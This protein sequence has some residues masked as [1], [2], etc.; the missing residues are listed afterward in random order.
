MADETPMQA[1]LQAP[2][3]WAD[4]QTLIRDEIE[5]K[6]PYI[7]EMYK[8]YYMYGN[9]RKAELQ[10][11]DE[12]RRTN[13]VSPI[14]NM[15]VSRL[16]NM[17]MEAD[18]RFVAMNKN[19]NIEDDLAKQLS[20]EM[21]DWAYYA[22]AKDESQAAFASTIFDAWL[23][24]RWVFKVGYKYVTYKRKYIDKQWW[25]SKELDIK[26]DYP[27]LYYISPY[28]I[29][30]DPAAKTINDA[31]FIAERKLLNDAEINRQYSIYGIS[32]TEADAKILDWL[33]SNWTTAKDFDSIKK[34]M[35]FYGSSQIRDI[36]EDSTYNIKRQTREVVEVHSKNSIT[37]YIN[38]KKYGTF[39]ALGPNESY[40]YKVI[41]FKENPWTLYSLGVWYVVKPLQD[42]YD[43]I[44]NLRLDNVKLVVNKV[45]M[46]ENTL[47]IMQNSRRMKLKPWDI[48]KVPTI[49]WVKEIEMTEIKESA[50]RE[51]DT[52]FQ[53][54]QGATGV[55]NYGLGIQSKIERVAG[56]ADQ[57][58]STLDSSVKP[59]ID[60]LRKVMWEVMKE[61]LIL[62]VAYTDQDEL[63]KV[64]GPWNKLKTVKLD[65]LVDDYIFDWFIESPKNKWNA[66]ENQQLLEMVKLAPAF[67]DKTTGQTIFGL[68]EILIKLRSNMWLDS[69]MVTDEQMANM[70]MK[71]EMLPWGPKP[72]IVAQARG[73]QGMPWESI[74]PA[75]TTNAKWVNA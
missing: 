45:F 2:I 18:R 54:A 31:R 21:L 41:N 49:S 3:E 33:E 24:G 6:N 57:L 15:F 27:V 43:Q 46:V 10:K 42:I 69:D 73:M 38:G 9:D 13:I 68:K 66:I 71:P 7:T 25:G 11:D 75:M 59:L 14:T 50:Y 4:L 23:I 16:Y 48:L 61:F 67:V 56:A 40:K 26:L 53:L 64:L 36:T 22:F 29:Y 12:L 63:D 47:N 35:P 51:T 55:S 58:Q 74:P 17:V 1:P 65:D 37:I 39:A 70:E 60:S 52:M 20:K 44:T 62:T 30:I 32:V 5:A 72:D 19:P 28:N 34:N 8:N